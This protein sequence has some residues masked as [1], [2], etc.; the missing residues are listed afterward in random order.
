MV[1][2]IMNAGSARRVE[3]IR[4]RS[5]WVLYLIVVTLAAVP[6]VLFAAFSGFS[7][8]DDEGTLLTWFQ[9]MRNGYRM[10]DDIYN[11]YG[12]L[13][14]AAY[15]LLYGV[16]GVPLTNTAARSIAASLW[17]AYTAGFAAFCYN[18]TRS[19]AA[20]ALC[21]VLVLMWLTSLMDSPG[22]PEEMC[23]LLFAAALLFLCSIERGR[24][25]MALAGVGIAGAGLAL[26]KINAG[27]F[28]G[29]CGILVLLCITARSLWTRI[30]IP[31]VAVGLLLLPA[32]LSALLFDFDWV[33]VYCLFST[34]V[35]GATLL[36]FLTVAKQPVLRLRDWWIVAAGGLFVCVAAVG[37]MMLAGSSAFAILDAVI[38]QNAQVVRNWYLPMPIGWEGL[39]TA[40]VSGCA[41]LACVL[42]GSRSAMR[43]FR[44][45]EIL[46]L[47]SAFAILGLG[48]FIAPVLVFRHLLPF[49]WLIMVVPQGTNRHTVVARCA[50]GLMGATMSLYSFP[51]AGHQMNIA[52]L[53][54]IV[55]LPIL[56][57][58]VVATLPQQERRWVSFRVGCVAMALVFGLAGT[59][60]VA[61]G[62]FAS[63]PLGLR[64]T[65]LIRVE[66]EQATDLRWA[67]E[68]LSS[69]AS[70]Y[71]VPGMY[72]F[73]F[74]T[75]H[76]PPTATNINA[77]LNFITTARQDEIV[78]ALSREPDL[79][80]VYNPT[81]LAAYDR[82]QI[83]TRPPLTRYIDAGFVQSAE[84]HGYIILRRRQ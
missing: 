49:C 73:S 61:R 41:A 79:C 37:A 25:A 27:A 70:S 1:S 60:R 66:R 51:V 47:K 3:P 31:I 55:M 18:V 22:H 6:Y 36:V 42:S 8:F 65:D 9:S 75:G 59:I 76:L 26:V 21:Y 29:G 7:W 78:Q 82:G 74:W 19:I 33:R 34:L 43:G 77:E 50:A 71:S 83:A 57:H 63:V 15:G 53:L 11:L 58:D 72:S 23:L 28:V 32:V 13:Y 5:G 16:L 12:P 48:L 46:V 68:Q 35:I 17:L 39:L 52:T 56:A 80:I 24:N 64:G 84:R 54:P 69:C 38:L 10:Y 62:Y 14:S 40:A 2:E 4:R 44:D 30:A 45:L 20:A 81:Q 67:T